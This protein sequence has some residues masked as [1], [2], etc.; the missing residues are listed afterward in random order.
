MTD[1]N[2]PPSKLSTRPLPAQFS[3]VS[4]TESSILWY[5][6]TEENKG[7]NSRAIIFMALIQHFWE[8]Y[9]KLKRR[10]NEKIIFSIIF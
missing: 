7:F 8:K 1:H 6:K 2:A 9:E 4:K 3:G 5:Q 10:H